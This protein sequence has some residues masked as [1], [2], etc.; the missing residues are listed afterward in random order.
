M[1]TY[2]MAASLALSLLGTEPPASQESEVKRLQEEIC[3]LSAEKAKLTKTLRLV[4]KQSKAARQVE[5]ERGFAK[6][7]IANAKISKLAKEGE[8]LREENGRLL[9][10]T[11]DLRERIK[12]AE[13]KPLGEDAASLFAE[14][15][16]HFDSRL[17]RSEGVAP[18]LADLVAVVVGDALASW[19]SRSPKCR[20]YCS[21]AID[22]S[23]SIT[24]TFRARIKRQLAAMDDAV[25]ASPS[26]LVVALRD[27]SDAGKAR[28][29]GRYLGTLVC[30]TGTV[31]RV[32]DLFSPGY[33][34]MDCG[35]AK[36]EMRLTA[37]GRAGIR[38][39]QVLC[40]RGRISEMRGESSWFSVQLK[41]SVRK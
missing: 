30:W 1:H 35:G 19:G 38:V 18:E 26:G 3:R 6:L 11:C 9:V 32:G 29:K 4:R 5:R 12:V 37:S 28:I 10:E 8:R 15:L 21:K 41:D 13:N 34:A 7:E 36:V 39:G 33:I 24:A 40:V 14:F 25:A 17:R 31:T 20:A 16:Q 2:L 27:T 23:N 22:W